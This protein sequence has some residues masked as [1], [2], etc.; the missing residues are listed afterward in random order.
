MGILS[1]LPERDYEG[2]VVREELG[3]KVFLLN[4][5]GT[6][7]SLE[8]IRSRLIS[9]IRLAGSQDEVLKGR[10]QARSGAELESKIRKLNEAA[11]LPGRGPG[12]QD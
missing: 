6:P 11:N 7:E 3:H 2:I 4:K 9:A 10:I 8:E 5:G 12:S 1:R